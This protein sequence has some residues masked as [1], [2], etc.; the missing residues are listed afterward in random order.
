MA[1]FRGFSGFE[2]YAPTEMREPHPLIKNIR[3]SFHTYRLKSVAHYALHVYVQLAEED[4][5]PPPPHE[6]TLTYGFSTRVVF[7][8]Y[9]DEELQ[10]RACRPLFRA[11]KLTD[12]VQVREKG[13][14]VSLDKFLSKHFP[15]NQGLVTE[16]TMRNWWSENG[17]TFNWSGLP[18]ELKNQVLQF[19][20]C[21][22]TG[23]SKYWLELQRHRQT[24]RPRPGP[25]E[26]VGLLGDWR[27]LLGVSHQVRSLVLPLV[28]VRNDEYSG[29]LTIVSQSVRDLK[30]TMDRL[31]HYL[32]MTEEDSVPTDART[33]ALANQYLEFPKHYPTLGRYA[34]MRHG[35]RK[36]FL[37]FN[38]L[39][40]LHF[41]KVSTGTIHLYRGRDFMTCDIF[42]KLP[43][44]DGL[45]IELPTE[46]W[47]DHPRQPG[48][49]LWHKDEPCPRTLHRFIY[50]RA[51]EELAT[52]NDVGMDGFMDADEKQRFWDHREAAMLQL[53]FTTKEL[54]D[55]YA[56]C[57]GGIQLG[58][59]LEFEEE[60]GQVGGGALRKNKV[61]NTWSSRWSKYQ[62][63]NR[64]SNRRRDGEVYSRKALEEG[65]LDDVF[66]PECVCEVPC[67]E[68]FD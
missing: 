14:W 46:R 8:P 53:R 1:S 20:V 54:E 21:N 31:G 18:T 36:L 59:G 47:K 17:K 11:K 16:S 61:G 19:C 66:P 10:I 35:I 41:F 68:V 58:V 49:D 22:P 33:I 29:G 57:S 9:L 63:S 5:D 48:P 28:L 23:T 26:V 39:D 44:L 45:H 50:E 30:S 27:A 56:E 25:H 67:R 34:T 7:Q 12:S 37:K 51:A 65:L 40:A 62:P 2:S 24:Y 60:G 52:Y 55:L 13:R 42:E 6:V 43:C 32:Q 64:R 3:E 4:D 15:P 38:F